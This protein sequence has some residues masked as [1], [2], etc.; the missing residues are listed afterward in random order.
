MISSQ[1]WDSPMCPTRAACPRTSASGDSL[2]RSG[3]SC[4]R[5][6]RC[7][8]EHRPGQRRRLARRQLSWTVQ[9]TPLPRPGVLHFEASYLEESRRTLL[10]KTFHWRSRTSCPVRVLEQTSGPRPFLN[11]RV[12]SLA[13]G[14]RKRRHE[15]FAPSRQIVSCAL[16]RYPVV[17]HFI[18]YINPQSETPGDGQR[19]KARRL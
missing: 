5:R 6:G 2:A 9:E 15:C 10:G 18:S 4:R 11:S 7:A 8:R 13:L 12:G 14:R 17:L 16:L 19:S 3:T 1:Y